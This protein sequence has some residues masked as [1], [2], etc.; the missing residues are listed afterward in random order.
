[1]YDFMNIKNKSGGMFSAISKI[2]SKEKIML[3]RY[4]KN[5]QHQKIGVVV[6]IGN[7]QIGWSAC[8]QGDE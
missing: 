8:Y 1:M 6:A 5:E 3:V 2:K 7:G 4:V